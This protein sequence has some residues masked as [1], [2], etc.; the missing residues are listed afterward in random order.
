MISTQLCI[1][2]KNRVGTYVKGV[3]FFTITYLQKIVEGII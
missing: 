1:N 2:M 3:I